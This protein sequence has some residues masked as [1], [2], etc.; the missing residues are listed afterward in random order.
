MG[1]AKRFW[2]WMA[3]RYARQPIADE[4]SYQRKLDLTAGF[5]TP[6]ARILEFGCGTGSTA[7]V[8]APKVASYLGVDIAENMVEIARGKAAEAGLD[9]LSFQV[10]TLEKA[11]L[12]D[13]SFEVVLGLNILH[14][15]PDLDRTLANVARVLVRGGIFVSSTICVDDVEGSLRTLGRATRFLPLFPT[16]QPLSVAGFESAIAAHGFTIE[17][18]FDQARGV[19]FRIARKTER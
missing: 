2:N 9:N 15:V 13:A 10:G 1:T 11:G 4:A 6:E 8:H 17:D 5:L 19:V 16:V 18:G 7:V 14:L 12:P 3:A